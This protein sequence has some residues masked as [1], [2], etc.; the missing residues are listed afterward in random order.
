MQRSPELGHTLLRNRYVFQ[1]G[2]EK[3][4]EK[5]IVLASE[6]ASGTLSAGIVLLQQTA[7]FKLMNNVV[8]SESLLLFV[9]SVKGESLCVCN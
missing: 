4:M 5:N 8:F 2:A 3:N 6:R 1:D 9:Y 7:V